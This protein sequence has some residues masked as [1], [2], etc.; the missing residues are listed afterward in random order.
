[1]SDT[2]HI[3]NRIIGKGHPTYIVAELSA[4]HG[5]KL[6]HAIALIHT[7]AKSGADAVK[8]QTYTA[9][10][11]T[12][13][14]N[15]PPFIHSNSSLWPGKSLYELYK[16]AYTPWEWHEQLLQTALDLGLD[17]FSSPFDASAV[18]FL[19][20][21][22]IPAFKISSFEIIDLPL[23]AYAAKTGRPLII[24][25]GMATLAEIDSAI[26]CAKKNGTLEIAILKCVSSYPATYDDMN[27]RTLTRL[28]QIYNL[29]IGLS[30]HSLGIV[31]PVVAVSLGASIVEKHLTLSKN[32]KTADQPFSLTPEEFSQMVDAIRKAERC[33][34]NPQFG[35]RENEKESLSFR[36]S[37]Y[38]TKDIAAGE[39]ITRENCRSI[40]PGGGIAP[41]Y[42]SIILG[43]RLRCNTLK[44]TPLTWD[45]LLED[46]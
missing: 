38:I 8:L 7:A 40:R 2:I 20:K 44:G 17:L 36:R 29:P 34:G 16:T 43:K 6:E 27:L 42:L 9:D 15:A 21:L 5:G 13:D 39:A 46:Y 37:L 25:T 22:E 12:I 32:L 31:A 14:C 1:M 33:L 11:M 4:N 19:E 28:Q 18:D 23:I 45:L 10:T 30:D 24:S 26:H 41:H 3:N 35:P